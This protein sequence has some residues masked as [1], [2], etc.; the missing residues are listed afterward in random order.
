M[1]LILSYS[2]RGFTRIE[3]IVVGVVIFVLLS[4][5]LPGNVKMKVKAQRI[6]CLHNLQDLGVLN[7][8]LSGTT[9][10]ND[11]LAVLGSYTNAGPYCWNYYATVVANAGR[12]PRILICPDDER[13]AAAYFAKGGA[14]NADGKGLFKDNTAVSYFVNPEQNVLSFPQGIINGD[15]NLSPGT[16][17]TNDYGFSPTNG[18]GNDVVMKAPVSW[19]LKMHSKGSV[20]GAG[21]VLLGDGSAQQLS[22]GML[23]K[24]WLPA[25]VTASTNRAGVRLVFP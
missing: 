22:S 5:L 13:T 17:P 19:S 2:R 15:R 25:T 7:R 16:V 8:L 9:S 3:L 24:N 23:N 20:A 1:K 18:S 4:I 6:Q 11:P 21:N 12:S 14:T 10:S